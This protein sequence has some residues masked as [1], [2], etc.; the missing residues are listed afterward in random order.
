MAKIGTKGGA[1]SLPSGFN[2]D[3]QSFD[4][5]ER[6]STED[7][8]TFDNATMYSTN[9]GT[10]TSTMTISATG[11]VN[12]SAPGFGTMDESGAAATFTI[13][14]GRTITG[15]FIVSGIR[16]TEVRTRATVGVTF[17]LINAGDVTSTV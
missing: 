4:V 13:D 16:L 14:S 7:T 6:Q 2:A 1:V 9:Q 11:F 8:T 5:N 15:T 12:A 17:D 10:G 3:F